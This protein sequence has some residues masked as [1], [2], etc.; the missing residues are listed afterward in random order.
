MRHQTNGTDD[1]DH[2]T[3]R[4]VTGWSSVSARRPRRERPTRRVVALLLM[5]PMVLG[6][7]GAP[8]G[9]QVARGDELSDAKAKQAQLKKEVAAQKARVAALTTLQAGLAAEIRGTRSALK[10][11]GADLAAV[12]KQITTMEV[13]IA[14]VQVAYESLVLQVKAMDAELGRVTAQETA[15]R[16]ELSERRA[17]LAER[18]RNAY[19]TDRTSPLE[20]FLSG[21]TFTDLLA[22]MSYYI[23]VGEQ[24]KALANQI[25][26]DQE[27][28][29]ALREIVA[30][31][32]QRTNALRQETAAQK[33]SLDRSL[34]ELEDTK[35][36]LKRLEAE[37]ARE[38]K[39]QQA[40]FARIARSKA[41][42]RQAVAEAAAAQRKLAA[43][44]EAMLRKQAQQGRIP[45]EFNGSLRWP[46]DGRVTQPFG[47]TGFAWEAP[48]GDCA[49]FHRGID[50]VKKDGAPIRAAGDGVV[51]FVG[52]NPYDAP[53][54]Q[55]WIV[56]I[57]HSAGI[58]TWY[59]HMQARSA[60]GIR[61]GASVRAGDIIGY[62]GSTGRSTGSH[63]HWAVMK[64]GNWVNPR[65][66]L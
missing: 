47:C 23:D 19:D 63:L 21:G 45:S 5:L 39:K 49:N 16:Q 20:T 41:A 26:K 18:V 43:K 14:E 38:L 34:I 37:T 64:D 13:R 10:A 66:F 44:I 36:E 52:Y 56:I 7:L 58:Q 48:L 27:T 28:L 53:G 35:A 25:T 57:A 1:R 51:V 42:A 6:L 22:E 55:A 9:T 62:Q 4:P 17:L 11:I 3:A 59:A 40:A 46:L 12:K 2:G 32:R 31:T 61:A 60:P 65:L 8:A 15:K 30:A 50:I 24:D 54:P 29:A 33:R